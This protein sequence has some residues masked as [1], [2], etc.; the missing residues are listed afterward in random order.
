MLKRLTA[1]AVILTAL[2][3]IAECLMIYFNNLSPVYSVENVSQALGRVR[4]FVLALALLTI[5]ALLTACLRSCNCAKSKIRNPL[6][7][8]RTADAVKAAGNGKTD[9]YLRAAR[10]G[11]FLLALAL[12]ICGIFNGSLEDVLKKAIAICTECIGLG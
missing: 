11:I 5:F 12:I 9:K 4:W 10:A 2:D 1:L 8:D 3:F 7:A 6:P